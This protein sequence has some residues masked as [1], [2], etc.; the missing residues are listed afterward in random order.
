MRSQ[1]INKSQFLLVVFFLSSIAGASTPDW[2][3]SLAQQ[4]Q[5]KY[6]DDV[7][8]VVLLDEGETTSER[9]GRF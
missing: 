1:A 5:K 3:R 6:A 7:N 2:L 4:P 8:A 9:Q